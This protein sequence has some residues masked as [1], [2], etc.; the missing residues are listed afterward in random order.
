MAALVRFKVQYFSSSG[1]L[2]IFPQIV[3]TILKHPFATPG[4]LVSV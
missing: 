1:D 3:E 4:C 2:M